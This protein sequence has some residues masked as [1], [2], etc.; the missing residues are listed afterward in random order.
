MY[1]RVVVPLDGS[2]LAEEAL[3]HAQAIAQ[4]FG[5]PL[6]L[7]RVVDD[8]PIGVYDT[9]GLGMGEVA[10][11]EVLLLEQRE[12]QSYL[13]AKHALLS[14]MLGDLYVT[15]ELRSGAVV[16]EL[17]TAARDGDLY[18]MAS[19]GRTGMQRWFMG[20]VAEEMTRQSRIPVML[21]RAMGMGERKPE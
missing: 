19:H 4:A 8:T 14:A 6:H 13:D 18:V 16:R 15:T 10:S 11:G 2:L 12:A 20:S 1:S 21:V 9:Y 7:L 3:P 5:I 17:L